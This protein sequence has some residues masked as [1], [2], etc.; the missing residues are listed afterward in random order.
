MSDEQISQTQVNK[1]LRVLA[2][3]KQKYTVRVHH[4]DGK[5]LE[6]QAKEGPSLKWVD[7]DRRLWICCGYG[8]PVMPWQEGMVIMTEENPK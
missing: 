1:A 5:V 8:N 6:F 3:T 2:G 7:D 4:A